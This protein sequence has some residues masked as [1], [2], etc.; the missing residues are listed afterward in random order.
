MPKDF[1]YDPELIADYIIREGDCLEVMRLMGESFVDTVITD[2]PYALVSGN[3]VYDYAHHKG[4]RKATGGGFMGKDWDSAIPG[5]EYWTEMLRLA[6]PGAFLVAFGGTRTWHRL[7]VAIEDAGWEIRD[8]LMWLYGQGFPKSMNLGNGHGTALKPAWEPII[9]AM[10]PL[11]GTFAQNAERWG[12]AGLNIDGCR[13][14]TE[15]ISNHGGGVN[16]GNR[17]YGGGKGIPAIP[18]GSYS[19]TGRFPANLLLDE[20]SA[21]ALDEQ[22]GD[23]RSRIGKPRGA[24]SGDGWGMTATGSEYSDEGGASRFFYTSKASNADRGNVK[25]GELPLFGEGEHEERN[26]HPTVK[27]TDLMEW[28]CRLTNTPDGKGL[29][30]DPFLG[31]GSTM[32]A[33]KRVGRPCIG[34]EKEPEYVQFAKKRLNMA[35]DPPA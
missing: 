16:Q 18:A 29:V 27:P 35:E 28:L 4:K 9:L 14:G 19:N 24:A 15:V 26:P 3:A 2:P 7:A 22:S 10:K 33:A 6:K 21:A 34:I 8:T 12:V 32:V 13:I 11:D 30:L 17:K 31:S 1:P 20:E 5:P 25:A 23:S